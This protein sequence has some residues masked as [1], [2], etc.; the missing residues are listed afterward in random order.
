[1]PV[2]D[3]LSEAIQEA[4]KDSVPA[5]SNEQETCYRIIDPLLSAIGYRRVEIKIQGKDD[6]GQKPDY[7]ILPDDHDH[8]WFLEAKA[9]NI[10][11]DDNHANQAVN[12]ANTQGK[13]WVVLSNG[14]EWR[15]YDNQIFGRVE[16]KTVCTVHLK[17]AEFAGFLEAIAKSSVQQE[18][19]ESFVQN[20]RLYSYLSQ[21]FASPKSDV[22]KAVTKVVKATQG[23]AAAT[24]EDVVGF[25]RDHAAFATPSTP[26]ES[27]EPV[28]SVSGPKNE[29]PLAPSLSEGKLYNLG[30]ITT[31]V[32]TG[33]KVRCL[34]L[35][36]GRRVPVTTWKGLTRE[37]AQYALENGTTLAIPFFASATGKRLLIAKLGT[38]QAEAMRDASRIASPHDDLL[39]ETNLSAGDQQNASVCLLRAVGIEPATFQVEI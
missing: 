2:R 27:P 4:I 15:L 6:A 26:V 31:D 20:R 36:D 30:R 1:M 3:E 38:P 12:Y 14:R 10:A 17:D 18:R 21:Q 37:V 19:L 13:R 16:D 28:A 24:P 32:I 34:I 23:L 9:W 22:I 35:P 5:P 29:R 8:T 25:L 33:S 39:I 7:T 11:L